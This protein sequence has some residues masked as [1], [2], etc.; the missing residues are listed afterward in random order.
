[1]NHKLDQITDSV[2]E[3]LEDLNDLRGALNSE[4]DFIDVSE[5]LPEFGDAVLGVSSC[6]SYK[7]DIWV[8]LDGPE[9]CDINHTVWY[10]MHDCDCIKDTYSYGF[11]NCGEPYAWKA[12]K[13]SKGAILAGDKQSTIK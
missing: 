3:M 11:D 8:L 13:K 4:G 7:K 6:K 9:E 10:R 12:I 5:R 2:N 1:M